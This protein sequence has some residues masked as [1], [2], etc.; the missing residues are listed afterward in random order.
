MTNSAAPPLNTARQAGNFARDWQVAE[1]PT[2]HEPPAGVVLSNVPTIR[3][4]EG[5]H[6]WL[7]EVLGVPV[8]LNYVRAATAKDEL[9]GVKMSGALLFSTQV[10]FDWIMS[11]YDIGA[12]A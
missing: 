11:R 6:R 3:G 12:T 9:T 1:V 5:A 7:N 8:R 4:R 2:K 10:L